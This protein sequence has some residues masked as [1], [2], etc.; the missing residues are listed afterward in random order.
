MINFASRDQY[1]E[2]MPGYGNLQDFSL[3]QILY[4]QFNFG[5]TQVHFLILIGTKIM[6]SSFSSM[7]SIDECHLPI[8]QRLK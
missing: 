2:M 3:N 8:G 6:F 4:T 5:L 1:N 7:Q